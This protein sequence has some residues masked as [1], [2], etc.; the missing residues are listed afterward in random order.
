M[1]TYDVSTS[2][3]SLSPFS[4]EII[5]LWLIEP[6]LDIGLAKMIRKD[7]LNISRIKMSGQ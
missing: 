4:P 7:V 2:D 5:V 1:T 3:T 6:E